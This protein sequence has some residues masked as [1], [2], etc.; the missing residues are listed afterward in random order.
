MNMKKYI[1]MAA[2]AMMFAA[3]SNDDM[4]TPEVD[5]MTDKPVMV[6]ADVAELA[7]RSGVLTSD[8]TTLSLTIY[9]AKSTAYSY[10]NVQYESNGGLFTP[11]GDIKP[12]WQNSTQEVTVSAWSPYIEGDLS[13]GYE[14]CV[15]AD[16]S[17]NDA[18]AESDFL[19]V[20]E[21]V[22]P[23]GVQTDKKITYNEGALNIGLQHAM[24]KLVVNIHLASEIDD[25]NVVVSNVAVKELENACLLDLS[26]F[27]VKAS[28]NSVKRDIIAHAETAASG[29]DAT[30]EAIFPPQKVAF[31]I[32]IELSDGRKFLYENAEFDF[33][34][35]YA[36]TLNLNAGKDKVELAAG[37]ITAAPWREDTEANKYLESE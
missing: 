31:S 3:C 1:T 10:T 33:L 7:T 27:T 23:D 12:L 15:K 25:P 6:N 26:T 30:F 14:F 8:L 13:N 22:D 16:Q 24:S 4:P 35:D 36:Y 21:T 11:V 17:G 37:G 20:T 34:S 19:W 18:S 5:A 9:N 2:V 29:Y 28:A 32:M